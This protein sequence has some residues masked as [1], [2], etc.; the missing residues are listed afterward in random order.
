MMRPAYALTIGEERELGEKLLFMVRNEFA[1]LDDP[2][3][4][5][6]INRLGNEVLAA[7]GPQHFNYH[8]FI[9]ESD[10]FNAFAAPSGLIF[11]YTGLI[12]TMKTEDELVS[13][14]AHE[15]GHVTSRHIARRLE[16]DTTITAATTA[17]ALASLALGNPALSQGLFTGSLAAGQAMSLH[18]SR[19]DEEEA[20]RLAY[21][22]MRKMER[23]PNAMV[24]MLGTMRRITRYRS[25]Q[26]P[27]YLLTHPDPEARLD[28]VQGLLSSD[29]K[30][31]RLR[32]TDD[33]AFLRMKYR[34][35]A[36]TKDSEDVRA[37]LATLIASSKDKLSSVM[38]EYGMALLDAKDLAYDLALERLAR[39]RAHFP[40]KVILLVDEAV[41][42]ME[43]GDK[44][45]AAVLLQKVLK[46]DPTDVYAMFHMARLEQQNGRLVKA[47]ELYAKVARV[48]PDYSR[49]YYEMGH[50]ESMQN[51]VGVSYFY[52]GKYY[53]YQGKIK[54]AKQYLQRME[55]DATVTQDYR[56]EA[57]QTLKR[58]EEL[59]EG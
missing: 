5:R 39:V 22:W 40:D 4:A 44:Q 16:K 38:A 9:I 1:V 28:Y 51:H 21:G 53:L 41:I 13:V 19:Q 57:T 31:D 48:M 33:F 6:Y 49:L 17:L 10:Q 54:L 37:H 20:D 56:D 2:D 55:K 59:E 18:Y 58:L 29:G 7:L 35:L 11:F 32:K 46:R 34:V 30:D 50:L 26:V 47:K 25:G 12:E 42:R 43:R 15:I 36:E 45:T 52:L 24:G 3:L 23:D 27:Q 14:L 8:F